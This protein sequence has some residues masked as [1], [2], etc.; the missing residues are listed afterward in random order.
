MDDVFVQPMAA[1]DLV[2]M[3]E[4]DDVHGW[5]VRKDIVFIILGV[6]KTDSRTTRDFRDVVRYS[7]GGVVGETYAAYFVKIDCPNI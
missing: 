3:R 5:I 4:F 2:F 6:Q 1:G 7:G